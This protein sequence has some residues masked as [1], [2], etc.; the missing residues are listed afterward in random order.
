MIYLVMYDI[1][2]NKKRTSIANICKDFG[3]YRIQKSVFIGDLSKAEKE[4]FKILNLSMIDNLKDSLYIIPIDRDLAI[5]IETLGVSFDKK[6]LESSSQV[7]FI[8]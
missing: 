4:T 2:E 6:I 5:E 7:F 3:L 8:W 1:I